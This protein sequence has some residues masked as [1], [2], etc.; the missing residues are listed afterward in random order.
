MR[1][2]DLDE[3]VVPDGWLEKAAQAETAVAAG[4]HPDE[5]ADVWRDLKSALGALFPEKKCWYC[6][7]PVD[8]ADNAVDHFRP[9]GRVFE[10]KN[11]HPG[12][13]WLAFERS[14][15]RYSCTFCNS[16]R[17]D[18][19]NGTVGGKA[20]HFPL[21]NEDGRLYEPGPLT[22]E[23]PVLL[24]PCELHDWEALGCRKENGKPCPASTEADLEHRAKVSIEIYHLD[25]EPTCKQR[26]AA[27]IRLTADVAQGKRLF[28]K[29]GMNDEFIVVAK[30][31]RRAIDRRAPFSGEMIFILR[32]ERHSDHPW[33]QKLLE[34]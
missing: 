12:Y 19:D 13:R 23:R 32:G 3:L 29:F 31:I 10:A 9:K 11:P 33:I 8:R 28:A 1:Y 34:S 7:S 5:H 27:A 18:V 15:F 14:N 20:D 4:G 30:K 17:K 22:Q 6:E 24:D 25:Y 2:I 16:R 21:L 26:H